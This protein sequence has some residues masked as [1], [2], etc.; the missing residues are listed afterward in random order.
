MNHY[1]AT[2]HTHVSALL[3]CRALNERGIKARMAPVPRSLS[4]SCGTCVLYDAEG[5]NTDGMDRDVEKI[6]LMEQDGSFTLLYTNE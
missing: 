6:F 5:P 1:T 4:S 3:T 2:F